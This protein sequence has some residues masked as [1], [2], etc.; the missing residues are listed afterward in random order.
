MDQHSHDHAAHR[1]IKRTLDINKQQQRTFRTE[2]DGT[3]RY[4]ARFIR[5]S[6]NTLGSW[7]ELASAH[8]H[9]LSLSLSLHIF[10]LI[11]IQ[12]VGLCGM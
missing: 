9:S 3:L 5:D 8:T 12:E 10:C 1:I 4:I 2:Y 11:A 6:S 7:Q